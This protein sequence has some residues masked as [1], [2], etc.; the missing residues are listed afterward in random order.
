[1]TRLR[2]LLGMSRKK[3]TLIVILLALV[4][5]G[6]RWGYQH[7]FATDLGN[8]EY[9]S[10]DMTVEKGDV[11]NSLQMNGRANF[12]STQKLTFPNSGRITGVYKKVGDLV[13]AGEV[14]ARMDTYEIDNQ[15]EKSKIDLENEQRSLE[16]AL[17]GSKR[18]LE[19]LQAEKK[20]Q[21]LLYEQQNAPTSL[22]LALQTVE[23]EYIN[24]KNE[25]QQAVREYEKKQKDYET[26]KKTY[27]EIL[28]LNKSGTILHSDEVLKNKVE[29]LKF[30]ADDV[31][32][33]LDTLDKIMLYTTKYG[34]TK[35]DYYMYIGAKDQNTKNQ[36]ERLFR[37]MYATATTLYTR[38]NSGQLLT[39]P[40]VELKSQLIQQYEVLKEVAEQKTALSIA[41]E[42]MFEASIESAGTPRS[43]VSIA[44]GRSLKTTANTAIDEI[45]GLAKPETI[46]EK[47]KSELEDLKLELDKQ[48]QALDKLKIEYDQLDAEKAKK[49]SDTKMDYE[50]KDLEVKIAK[51]ELD[52]LKKGENEE[53]KQIRNNIKQKQKE[54]ETISKRYDD[55]TLKANFDGVV[56]KMNLQVGDTVGG[57]QYGNS[58][59]EK[60][61][62]IENPDNLEIKL[63]VDQTDIAKLSVGM[64]V[65]ILLD[66]LP[67]SPYTGT[68]VEID[69]TAGDGDGYGGGGASY[70]AKV[71]FTK[72]P[73]DI[74][75]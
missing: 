9:L 18:D 40:E 27:D 69:T 39:L 55:Y 38:A 10:N 63:N 8:D 34:T 48:Q 15:L 43:R 33:E 49:I 20:Y 64:P 13:K 37:E 23:N 75:L 19:I 47:A 24:K 14:I 21:A 70:K 56:T 73:D 11:I 26:K 6:G 3:W 71:V 62:S 65:K 44:D 72:K 74:I 32:K 60:S 29:D 57:G 5:I 50:M 1:M 28:T 25:Y 68:L 16:K 67:D 54:I 45:L 53:V 51:T 22:K 30:T 36:V 17:D 52:D 7:F 59:E 31:R 58:T 66:A 41:V 12:S 35:P 4:G 2:K 46:G 42:K 61:V